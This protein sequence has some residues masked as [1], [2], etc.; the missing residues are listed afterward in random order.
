[1][2]QDEGTYTP[3]AIA[4]LIRGLQEGN[5][6]QDISRPQMEKFLK[7]HKIYLSSGEINTFMT[8]VRNDQ[9]DNNVDYI[10]A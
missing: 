4:Q 8:V 3:T 10:T 6:E 7:A 2:R 9:E 1:M 5:S